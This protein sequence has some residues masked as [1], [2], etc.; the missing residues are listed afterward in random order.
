MTKILGCLTKAGLDELISDMKASKRAV[1]E[2]MT[3]ARAATRRLDIA[4]A[5]AKTDSS[6]KDA[7]AGDTPKKRGRPKKEAHTPV[8][9][10]TVA[11]DV[12][13]PMLTFT[14]GEDFSGPREGFDKALPAILRFVGDLSVAAPALSQASTAVMKKFKT[15]PHYANPG[16]CHKRLP[17]QAME[18]AIKIFSK[19]M[20]A[21]LET[22]DSLKEQLMP[23]MICVADKQSVASSETNHFASVR[24]TIKGTREVVVVDTSSLLKYMV[25]DKPDG[26]SNLRMAYDWLS[27]CSHDDAKAYISSGEKIYYATVGPRDA[28]YLPTGMCFF[29]LIKGGDYCAA[30]SQF[31]I[32]GSV[33]ALESL[34]AYFQKIKKPNEAVRQAIDA[35]YLTS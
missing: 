8:K 33:A 4:V 28:L 21:E 35:I 12:C 34:N 30:R 16:R 13:T 19:M 24:L 25:K 14:L 27:A 18:E 6:K 29:E 7:A 3:M 1:A 32:K 9:L 15:M 2:L 10:I 26:I 20:P 5:N 31:L 22:P 17:E 11:G 23:S